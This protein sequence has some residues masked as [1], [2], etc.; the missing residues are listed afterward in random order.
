MRET[1]IPADLWPEARDGEASGPDVKPR[2]HVA[3]VHA[4]GTICHITAATSQEQLA[5]RLGQYVRTNA[6]YQLW[7]ADADRVMRFLK[8]NRSR[9]A[10]DVYFGAMGQRWDREQLVVRRTTL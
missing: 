6:P 2:V 1:T 3:V 8:D 10:I 5:D 7:P 9:D 4:G